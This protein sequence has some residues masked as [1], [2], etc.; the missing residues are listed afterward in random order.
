MTP[1]REPSPR[2]KELVLTFW[3]VALATV[4]VLFIWFYWFCSNDYCDSFIGG[5]GHIDSFVECVD[6]G[7][8]VME[9]YPRQCR[10]NEKTFYEIVARP[11]PY[12]DMIE[13]F[14]L[15]PGQP[16]SDGMYVQGRAR[17]M[18]FFEASFPV[19]I[20]D[21]N[22]KVLGT[23]VATAQGEW[24]TENY[25]EFMVQLDFTRSSTPTGTL[26]FTKDNPSGLSEH[27]DVYRVPV[28]FTQ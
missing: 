23:N 27:D 1:Q 28:K 16:V 24:M 13:V 3:V 5:T 12:A 19:V 15:N 2:L 9:S 6:A 14:N 25:V 26:E 18:W 22:G 10:A 4:A 7:N 11:T 8:P 17:G 20:K 21:A